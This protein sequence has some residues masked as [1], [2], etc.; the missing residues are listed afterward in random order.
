[1][2]EPASYNLT[3]TCRVV[4]CSCD[5]RGLLNN[6]PDRRSSQL[7][8]SWA[9]SPQ[10]PDGL[11]LDFEFPSV[12]SQARQQAAV[13]L[14]AVKHPQILFK[15]HGGI[16]EALA[17]WRRAQAER[18]VQNAFRSIVLARVAHNL[19]VAIRSVHGKEPF[20]VTFLAHAVEQSAIG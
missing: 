8:D 3:T 9:I 13:N 4:C 20:V 14:E 19:F 7:P 6:L 5:R 12:E 10:Y 17:I 2:T 15:H 18:R 16:G 11:A 1:M